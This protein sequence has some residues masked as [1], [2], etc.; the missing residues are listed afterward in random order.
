MTAHE[1]GRDHF[2][3]PIDGWADH[4]VPNLNFDLA[5][6]HKKNLR[7]KHHFSY[8]KSFVRHHHVRSIFFLS[9]E[10]EDAIMSVK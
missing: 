5:L 7:R 4:Y 6:S 9:S 2:E 10:S 8:D 3:Y 1:C